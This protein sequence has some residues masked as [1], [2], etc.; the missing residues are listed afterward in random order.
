MAESGKVRVG[1][2]FGGRSAEHEISIL[3]ARNVLA[4]LDLTRFEPVLIGIDKNGRWLTQDAKRL[5]ASA[6]DPR[7]VHIESGTPTQLPTTFGAGGTASVPALDVIFPVLHGTLGEDGAVQGL[8]EVAGIPYVGAG[9]LGSAIGMDKDVMK[10]LLRDAGIAVTPFLTLRRERFDADPAAACRKL[11][12]LGLPLFVKPA[13]AG[14]S[15]GITKIKDFAEIERA[16]RHAFEFDSKIL[17]E[18]AVV[19]REIELAVLGGEPPTVSVAGEI[20]VAHPDGFYS[21]DAKYIDEKGV[22]F[23]LPAHLTQEEQRRAQS[24]ALTAFEVLECEGLARVDLFM[25]R[26]GEF[27]VNEINTL[28]GFTAISMY[29]KLWAL[30]G[31]PQQELVTRLIELALERSRRRASLKRSI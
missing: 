24:I 6:R 11:G 30:S 8:L 26:A 3:S 4:A 9:V 1:I 20:V 18:T 14:S 25:T 10:R 31:I 2:L 17:G 13:N 23:D 27:L 28:P 5:L 22:T 19:G 7:R 21:Y 12:A 15:V 16:A 29:P